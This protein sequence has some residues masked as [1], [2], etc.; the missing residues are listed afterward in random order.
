MA[1]LDGKVAVIT[2]ASSGIGEAT[3]E[4]LA[5]EGAAVVV[6]ARREER[7]EDVVGRIEDNASTALAVACDVTDEEQAHA[8]IRKAKEEFGRVDILVNNAGIQ[9]VA[10]IDQFPVD[11]WN[12]IIAINLT[13]AFHTIRLALPRVKAKGWG[14]VLNIASAHALVASPF[15]AAYVAAKHGIAGLTKVVALELATSNVTVNCICPGPIKTGM[16]A[17]IDDAAKETYAKRRVPLRRY[18][19]PEEV[20]QATLSLVLPAMSYVNGNVLIADGGMLAQNT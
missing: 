1:K 15:K 11:Q 2:G 17:G 4:A 9:H 18:G 19:D 14:R 13:A 12:A 10:P 7:L 5:A 3:A 6:A 16:T 20:A 8:L